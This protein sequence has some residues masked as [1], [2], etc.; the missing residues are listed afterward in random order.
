MALSGANLYTAGGFTT[1][2]SRDG[3]GV[4][5][6]YIAQWDGSAWSSLGAGLD[7]GVNVLAAAG[8]RSYVGGNFSTAFGTDG[9]TLAVNGIAQWDG[10]SWAALGSGMNNA[11]MALAVSGGRLYAGGAFTTVGTKAAAHAAEAVPLEQYSS[12]TNDGPGFA[13]GV[14][15]IRV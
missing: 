5:V 8:G 6:N 3:V 10:S 4:P 13:R 1:A 15:A 9:E 11:V 12:A 14:S 2:T 7:S